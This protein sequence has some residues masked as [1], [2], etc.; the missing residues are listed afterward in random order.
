MKCKFCDCEVLLLVSIGKDYADII[1]DHC[2]S[3]W[4]FL[5]VDKEESEYQLSTCV[6]GTE[7]AEC[8]C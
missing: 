5:L 2:K 4:R 3:Q 1:C 7:G 8:G 6:S